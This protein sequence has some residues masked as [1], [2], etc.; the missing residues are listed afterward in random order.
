METERFLGWG[1]S[2]SEEWIDG[3]CKTKEEAMAEGQSEFYGECFEIMKLYRKDLTSDFADDVAIAMSWDGGRY[4]PS[5]GTFIE[6]LL[7]D[8]EGNNE[9]CFYEDADDFHRAAK[10]IPDAEFD[11]IRAALAEIGAHYIEPSDGDVREGMCGADFER[12][13]ETVMQEW[14]D[15]NGLTQTANCCDTSDHETIEPELDAAQPA[16]L[17]DQ[18]GIGDVVRGD[19]PDHLDKV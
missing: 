15:K 17:S 4:V 2:Q 6:K 3:I 14:L 9:E 13:C 7:M 8:I 1:Y 12:E 10:K 11:A 18:D 5:G 19:G 16:P